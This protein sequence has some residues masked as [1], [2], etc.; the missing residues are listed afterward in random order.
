MQTTNPTS[1]LILNANIVSAGSI[2]PNSGILIDGRI[3]NIFDMADLDK[4]KIPGNDNSNTK[5][6]D[7]RGQIT[8]PGLIDTHIHGIAG[9]STDENSPSAILDMSHA[10][11]QHGITSFIPTLYSGHPD[12]MVKEASSVVSAMGKETGARILG[13]HMEG[14]FLSPE[15]SGAQDKE[16]MSLPSAEIMEKLLEASKGN[17]LAMTVAPELPG[18]EKVVEI[19]KKNNVV[20]L[21]GHTNATYQQAKRGT[22]LGIRHT[23]HMFN[24]MSPLSHKNPGVAGNSLINDEMSLEI[25]ADGVHVNMDLVQYVIRTKS[26]EKVVLITDSLGPTG[27]GLGHYKANA[28]DIVLG[29]NGAFVDAKDHTKLCGSALTLNK[30]VANVVAGGTDLAKAVK[31]ATENPAK[32]YSLR[33]LGAISR[34][35]LADI[36]IFNDSLIPQ[37]VLING[38]VVHELGHD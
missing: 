9:R 32:I 6:I 21:M 19:A 23:T 25:I 30:A 10:L 14:P 2:R 26:T 15:K 35:F 3:A 12:K 16:S 17:L 22:E 5:I 4:I 1:T 7:A 11:A 36:V 34:G 18:I 37:Y 27:L 28:M 29:E 33:G 8:C 13:I 20:L 31:L 24:A 38:K